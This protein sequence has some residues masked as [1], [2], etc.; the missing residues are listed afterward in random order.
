MQLYTVGHQFYGGYQFPVSIT[1]QIEAC[2]NTAD[3]NFYQII[4]LKRET[5]QLL[6]NGNR[7]MLLGAY[8]I[9]LNEKDELTF[10]DELEQGDHLILSFQPMV[11]NQN[12]TIEVCNY[13]G[14]LSIPETQDIFYFNRF[15]WDA[16]LNQKILSLSEPS[17]KMINRKFSR[18]Q[19]LLEKQD[20]VFWPC[21]CRTNTLEMLFYLTQQDEEEQDETFE[22][23][24]EGYSS[25]VLDVMAYLQLHYSEKITLEKL[26]P[27]FGTN[28]TTLLNEFKQAT[29]KSLNQYL[30]QMRLKMAVTLLRDTLI[31][32]AEIC[33][34]TGFYD[35][36]YFTRVF[37]GEIHQTPAEYR[38][39]YNMVSEP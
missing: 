38:K 17:A 6:L 36:S 12:L 33:E 21:L 39:V 11:F 2:E 22:C 32:I 7:V 34:R 25:L 18:I 5:T 4:Y 3:K 23:H 10:I 16:R 28:R 14:Q 31:P 15:R 19:A 26:A 9:C 20:D 29:G 1:E 30:R 24:A 35:M 27:I 8:I 13:S 37:K